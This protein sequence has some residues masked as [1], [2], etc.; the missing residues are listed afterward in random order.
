MSD[1]N[2]PPPDPNGPVPGYPPP[3]PGQ[4]APP[5]GFPNPGGPTPQQGYQAP[6]SYPPPP[7]AG[8]YPPP[9]PAAVPVAGH[10][11]YG[12]ALGYGWRKFTANPAPFLLTMLI[13]VGASIVLWLLGIL[14]NVIIGLAVR[15]ADYSMW[16]A[17]SMIH[18]G[19]TLVFFALSVFVFMLIGMALVQASID[20][21][22][23][24]PV[25]LATAFRRDKLSQYLLYAV[26]LVGI[27][28][29]INVLSALLNSVTLIGGSLLGFVAQL[30]ISVFFFY[31]PFLILDRGVTAIEAL[32]SSYQAA[33]ANFGQTILI[34]L[35][36]GLVAAAGTIAFGIGVFVT[37]PMAMIAAASIY[38][39]V[40]GENSAP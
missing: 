2:P 1:Q 36:I 35:V 40:H 15:T 19:V 18:W 28:I 13:A 29:V 37:L 30:A 14:V 21:A 4:P 25:T 16:S 24:V 11:D 22:R 33:M 6:G 12:V 5:P 31:A 9:A 17:V 38:L 10:V 32:K 26:I 39:S 23:G 7:P 20:T 8:G 3:A 27:G 34:V